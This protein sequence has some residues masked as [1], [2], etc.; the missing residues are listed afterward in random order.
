MISAAEEDLR[1]I[2]KD[3]REIN[4]AYDNVISYGLLYHIEVFFISNMGL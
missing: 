3:R 1:R 4:A 2:E